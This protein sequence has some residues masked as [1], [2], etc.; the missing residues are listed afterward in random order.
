MERITHTRSDCSVSPWARSRRSPARPGR[1]ASATVSF[2]RQDIYR[3]W[4]LP[5]TDNTT[6]PATSP[7][8]DGVTLSCR[9]WRRGNR[10]LP[11]SRSV[12]EAVKEARLHRVLVAEHAPQLSQLTLFEP[13][14]GS[15]EPTPPGP[16]VANFGRFRP[17]AIC[18]HSFLA[19]TWSAS[20]RAASS[21]S[22]HARM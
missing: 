2:S 11:R 21:T 8:C 6:N 20:L 19:G 22:R 10:R 9:V 3:T 13:Q 4:L 12:L 7:R 14:P 16:S 5:T 17:S 1:R 15:Q 18:W